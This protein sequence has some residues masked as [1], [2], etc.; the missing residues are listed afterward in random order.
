MAART[1]EG[2]ELE[3]LLPHRGDALSI[4]NFTLEDDGSATAELLITDSMLAI[5]EGHF[6]GNPII[7]GFCLIEAL[8]LVGAAL[9]MSQAGRTIHD[10]IMLFRSP[11]EGKFVATVTP[12]QKVFVTATI[13]R[14]KG[15]LVK[16]SGEAWIVSGDG[17]VPIYTASGV[18]GVLADKVA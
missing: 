1:L 3:R 12:A 2:S 13:D 10:S 18:S 11:G 9:A 6:P 16:F 17:R 14:K 7:P 8:N 4:R 5:I 15:G